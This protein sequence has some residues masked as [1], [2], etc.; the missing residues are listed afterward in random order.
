MASLLT[1]TYPRTNGV[2]QARGHRLPDSLRLLSELFS[3]AGYGTGAVVA[4]FNVGRTFGFDRGF[5]HF[6]ESWREGWKKEAGEQ[7]FERG[8]GREKKYTDAALVTTQGLEVIR[9][10]DDDRPFF[11]WLHYMDPHGPY[12]P[13]DPYRDLFVADHP[14]QLTSVEKIPFYQVQRDDTEQPILDLGFYKAQYD[15]E[16]R[17]LDSQ[18]G[19]LF[20]EIEAMHSERELII[21]L[22]ADHGESLDEHD[23]Y[24]AHGKLPYQPNARVPCIVQGKSIPAGRRIGAPV[25]LVDLTASI[26]ELAGL[27]IPSTFEGKSLA[28][29]VRGE[30]AAEPPTHVF[31]ESGF[32]QRNPQLTIREGR[33]KLIHVRSPKDRRDMAGGEYELYDVVADPQELHDRSAEKP[34]IVARLAA[35]LSKWYSSGPRRLTPGEIDPATLTPRE[36]EMLRELGYVK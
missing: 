8:P 27:D 7:P 28:G 36:V 2:I 4:N 13:P 11:V 34:E 14:P 25:G 19:R 26:V 6:L 23:Y 17:Y 16:I 24:L 22:T 9:A 33:W 31:M 1:G 20:A 21:V 12:V 15:A 30:P 29:L 32:H 18:L 35:S 10:L 3:D 5:H